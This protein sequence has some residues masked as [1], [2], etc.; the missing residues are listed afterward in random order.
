MNTNEGGK[1]MKI[2]E[3]PGYQNLVRELE[4]HDIVINDKYFAL[5]KKMMPVVGSYVTAYEN[6]MYIHVLLAVGEKAVIWDGLYISTDLKAVQ[7]TWFSAW[8]AKYAGDVKKCFT[9]R[10]NGISIGMNDSI[11]PW[12]PVLRDTE[13]IISLPSEMEL[14]QYINALFAEADVLFNSIEVEG[15]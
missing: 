11:D 8:T 9:L 12:F 5:G 4:V 7:S 13:R 10:A 2:T 1:I 15:E 6:Y 14:V 3:M